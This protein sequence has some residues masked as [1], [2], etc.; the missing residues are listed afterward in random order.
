MSVRSGMIYRKIW[1]NSRHGVSTASPL[2]LLCYTIS[3]WFKN[4][5]NW[6]FQELLPTNIAERQI[7]FFGILLLEPHNL[8]YYAYMYDVLVLTVRKNDFDVLSAL[9][10]RYHLWLINLYIASHQRVLQHLFIVSETLVVYCHKS[11]AQ[12]L[13]F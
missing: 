10:N 5:I 3:K 11:V 4:Y 8:L 6:F 1:F 9:E 13:T 12:I 7:S 2:K